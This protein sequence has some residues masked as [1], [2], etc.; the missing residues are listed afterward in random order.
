M[1][2]NKENDLYK[3][4][5]E[6]RRE[7]WKKL[8]DELERDRANEVEKKKV[9]EYELQEKKDQNLERVERPKQPKEVEFEIE[10]V[11]KTY[12]I[13]NI[14]SDNKD[15]DEE[16]SE[17]KV[18]NNEKPKKIKRPKKIKKPEK[19]K[20]SKKTLKERKEFRPTNI[21]G[22]IAYVELALSIVAAVFVWIN[23]AMIGRVIPFGLG[24]SMGS[25]LVGIGLGF[26][27]LFQG[28][29]FFLVIITI[30]EI[31][32]NVYHMKNKRDIE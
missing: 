28:I 31:A 12:N 11:E 27:I 9:Y 18:N 2:S 25:Y 14:Q 21:L 19:S 23:T 16:F 20:E 17:D 22:K 15:H 30:K 32:D 5:E 29:L 6:Q 3:S 8:A 4:N 10:K 24:T 26:T 7:Y 13:E 1:N